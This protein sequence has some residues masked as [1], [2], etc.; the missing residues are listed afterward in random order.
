MAPTHR[1]LVLTDRPFLRYG[2]EVL[3]GD[4][5][6]LAVGPCASME[7]DIEHEVA[8]CKPDV[9]V[10]DLFLDDLQGLTYLQRLDAQLPGVP[11]LVLCLAYDPS[12]FDL[13]M[14]HGAAGCMTHEE[15]LSQ[16][17]EAIRVLLEGGAY[18]TWEAPQGPPTPVQVLS[19]RE[20]QI[21]RLLGEG[22]RPRHIAD[23]LHV[24]PKTVNRHRDNM[25]RKLQVD[26][27]AA[28]D[29]LAI[30]WSHTDVLS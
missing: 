13:A 24:S 22:L 8:A 6:S 25:V 27:R 4:E 15:A 2:I 10:L 18:R 7:D 11:I 21:F 9:V 30:R 28:L 26:G 20:L 17:P 19:M 29:Q 1:I 14:A 12:Y 23:Q 3:V 16:L 5:P